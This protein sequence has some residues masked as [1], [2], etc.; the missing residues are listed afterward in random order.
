MGVRGRRKRE[1][2]DEPTLLKDV[3]S[4]IDNAIEKGFLK[5]YE[6]D[7]EQ[8]V[9]NEGI[10]LEKDFEM[11]SSKSGSLSKDKK[12]GKW[13]IRVNGKHHIKRQRFTIAHEF[14]HYCLHKDEQ[15]SFVDEEIYFRK[16]H[17]SSIEYNADVFAS[18]IL[19][20]KTLFEKAINEAKIKKIKELSD[21]FNV[22]T[23]AITI[24]AEKLGF[25]TKSHEK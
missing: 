6:V 10:I 16:D 24:R 8:I 14:A 17:E 11:E 19:M 13:V 15:G 4:I 3:Q 2:P 22:S 18:E 23:M 9:R 5:N 12:I 21:I 7:I 1:F 20:P 25:K